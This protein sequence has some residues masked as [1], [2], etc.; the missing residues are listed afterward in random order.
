[1]DCA[2]YTGFC[3]HIGYF[4]VNGVQAIS[5]YLEVG[6]V[7][8][9]IY[10]AARLSLGF[11]WLFTGITSEFFAKEIGREVL[12]NVGVLGP[13]ADYAILAGSVLDMAIGVWLLIGN[14]LY[15]CYLVQ[16]LVIVS[17]TLLLTIIEPH[18]WIH[19]FGP[20]TKNIPILVLIYF[21]YRKARLSSSLNKTT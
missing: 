1:M 14:K 3:F 12:A 8:S 18:Y 6:N 19:P 20:L 5:G 10:L 13:V 2:G 15:L 4:L 16:M 11:L 21:L 17:Y 9:R 7:N